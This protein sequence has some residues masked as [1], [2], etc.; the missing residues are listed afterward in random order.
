[1]VI[2]SDAFP[3]DRGTAPRCA[4]TDKE[5]VV[6]LLPLLPTHPGPGG[7]FLGLPLLR[8]LLPLLFTYIIIAVDVASQLDCRCR[9]LL[10]TNRLSLFLLP[11]KTLSAHDTI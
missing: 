6:Y 4:T 9:C 1:M 2:G 11:R 10:A 8:L 3:Q 5:G 7:F